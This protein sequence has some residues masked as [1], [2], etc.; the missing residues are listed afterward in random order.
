MRGRVPP[1]WQ[2]VEVRSLNPQKVHS[3]G[4]WQAL[5]LCRS[6]ASHLRC[7][8]WWRGSVRAPSR[9]SPSVGPCS[10]ARVQGITR[11]G[12]CHTL[13]HQAG[14]VSRDKRSA[15]SCTRRGPAYGCNARHE[16][17]IVRLCLALRIGGDQI[18]IT[19]V[20]I[21][22]DSMKVIVAGN[23]ISHGKA[24]PLQRWKE[25]SKPCFGQANSPGGT[26]R[27]N[28][29]RLDVKSH[30]PPSPKQ[31]SLASWLARVLA[32]RPGGTN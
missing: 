32:W 7:L 3:A 19:P 25:I 14:R 6:L 9:P 20:D 12:T 10:S 30:R 8:A 26:S 28:A 18:G 29:A 31:S 23:Y 22:I 16:Q 17:V 4:H 13:T 11:A 21:Q 2:M 27:R 5:A 1:P 24:V 15:R